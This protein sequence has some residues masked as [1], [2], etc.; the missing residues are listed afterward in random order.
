MSSTNSSQLKPHEYGDGSN[1]ESSSI[2]SNFS[3][4]QD[5][6]E[7]P[8]APCGFINPLKAHEGHFYLHPCTDDGINVI[9]F[10]DHYLHYECYP[11]PIMSWFQT[12][13]IPSNL[14][15]WPR[16]SDLYL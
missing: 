6:Q 10:L 3:S 1:D 13:S 8:L 12:S 4:N 16:G 15:T 9:T 11:I 14:V 5:D 2:S 7:Q